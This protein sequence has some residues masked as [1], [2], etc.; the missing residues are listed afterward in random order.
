MKSLGILL[1]VAGTLSLVYGGFTYTRERHDLKLGPV[2]F[3]V[4]ARERISVP[5]RAGAG[6]LLLLLGSRKK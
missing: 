1:I 6:A 3:S 2:Q 5:V 4:K